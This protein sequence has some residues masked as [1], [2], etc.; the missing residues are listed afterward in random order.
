MF[1]K[2][3][4]KVLNGVHQTKNYFKK[5]T[6]V[7]VIQLWK[8]VYQLTITRQWS[9][10]AINWTFGNID[11]VLI[12]GTHSLGIYLV[13]LKKISNSILINKS[14]NFTVRQKNEKTLILQFYLVVYIGLHFH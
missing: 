10:C 8:K 5:Q 4:A 7:F 13:I 14:V 3:I 9:S 12:W 6:E 11:A 2:I 1:I